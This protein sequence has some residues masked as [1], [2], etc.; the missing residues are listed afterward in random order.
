MVLRGTLIL[1]ILCFYE[2][3]RLRS[4]RI[5]VFNRATHTK[6]PPSYVHCHNGVYYC[7]VRVHVTKITGSSSDDWIYWH[8]GYKFS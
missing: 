8:F 6:G 3:Y 5:Y 1:Q 4:R 2:L 7:H